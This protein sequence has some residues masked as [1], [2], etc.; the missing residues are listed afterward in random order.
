MEY[1]CTHPISSCSN[2]LSDESK[3]LPALRV[4]LKKKK[5]RAGELELP[6]AWR[7]CRARLPAG[8]FRAAEPS[9]R[10]AA[11][12]PAFGRQVRGGRGTAV[13]PRASRVKPP[14][15]WHRT[16]RQSAF[17]AGCSVGCRCATLPAGGGEDQA[18]L[19]VRV[20]WGQGRGGGDALPEH[21][22]SPLF[23]E[24]SVAALPPPAHRPWHPRNSTLRG[25]LYSLPP[26]NALIF[27]SANNSCL[28]VDPQRCLRI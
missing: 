2:V 17:A 19:K 8:I 11:L 21:L 15:R 7:S 3:C 10:H 23:G 20:V 22:P 9:R 25:S 1:F 13:P 18:G 27:L 28:L 5:K 26:L 24:L 16:G 12:V 14:H 4:G 6:V